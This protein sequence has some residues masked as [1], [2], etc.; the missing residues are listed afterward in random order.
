MPLVNMIDNVVV[1]RRLVEG[2][3]TRTE[4]VSLFGQLT[5]M[6]MAIVNLPSVITSAI[7][8]S[9][10]PSISESF[11]LGK[12]EKARK[13]TR[14]AIKVTLLVVLPCAF[15]IASLA[16][17]IMQLLYPKEPASL[18]TILFTISPAI[19]FLGLIFSLNGI[20]QGMGKP[21][22]PVLAL[23]IGM[24]FKIAIS[25][26]LTV[27]PDINVLGSGLGT[28]T[29]YAVASLIEI[30]FVK[31][32]MGVKFGINEFVIKPLVTVVTMFAAVKLSY[33]LITNSIGLGNSLATVISII[34][35]AVVYV[36]ALLGIGGISKEEILIMPKG[37]KL[38][39]ILRKLHLIR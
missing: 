10:V 16:G 27:D 17:P 35:G 12:V 23:S 21:M 9:L 11:A 25:Y 31:K 29:A 6:A 24:V 30:H 8:M 18:G 14:S 28:V 4:A 38:Y 36:L 3:F 32:Y 1:I 2:G 26:T 19:I 34:I 37:E 13:E 7:G 39:K 22:V 15:G 20:L 33:G 5:G